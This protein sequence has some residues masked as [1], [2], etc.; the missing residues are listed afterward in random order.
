MKGGKKYYY[1]GIDAAAKNIAAEYSHD[2]AVTVLVLREIIGLYESAKI[3]QSYKDDFFETA[4]HSPITGELEF[5]VARILY[6]LSNIYNKRWKIL[7]RRQ[8]GKTAPDIRLVK[9]GK[10]FA[11]IEI[12][13]KAGW[14]QPFLSPERFQNDLIKLRDG[15]SS[16]DPVELVKNSKNQLNKYF[17]QFGIENC[18]VFLLLPTMA[19]VHRKK[20]KTELSGYYQYFAET[21]GL[22]QKNLILLSSNLEL[23]LSYNIVDLN[24]TNDFEYLL[25]GLLKY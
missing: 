21:S 22:P 12:K 18:D 20:Y 7:L 9:D 23:D 5:F 11:I 15:K 25:T 13:A 16:Y 17:D 8:E 6:H 10:T 24:P 3:E 4:Y 2:R 14:I 1:D 19:L